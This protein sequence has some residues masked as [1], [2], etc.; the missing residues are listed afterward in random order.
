MLIRNLTNLTNWS[1]LIQCMRIVHLIDYFQPKI[2]YQETFLAREHAKL[3][4]DVTVVT[5]DRYFPFPDYESTFTK[6]LGERYVGTGK[7]TEEGIA[8]WRLPSWEIPKSPLVLLK[9]LEQTLKTVQSDVVFCHGV[10][11]LTSYMAARLKN[12]VGYTLVYDSHA[13]AFNTPLTDTLAKRWYFFLYQHVFAPVIKKGMNHLFAVGDDEQ[14]FLRETLKLVDYDVPIIRLGVDIGRFRFSQKERG[15]IRKELGISEKEVVVVCA[16]KMGKE[17]DIPV[18]AEAVNRLRQTNV[19]LLLI[20]GGLDEHVTDRA[21]LPA[22]QVRD[23][24]RRNIVHLPYVSNEK[25]PS[26]F[27]T[28]DIGVWPGNFTMTILEA[29]SC[30][31]PVILPKQSSAMYLDKSNG[32]QW[33]TRGNAQKLSERIELLAAS[34]DKR[35][36]L[37]K[38]ARAYTQKELSWHVIAN[39]TLHLISKH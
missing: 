35:M 33:F 22:R 3:G 16:G 11:S 26:Y 14:K 25:L 30:S 27:S 12:R 15:R 1:N 23:P 37:G 9:S 4:H 18:L 28:A 17:K 8:T 39:Q 19:R 21:C 5:S 31:L 13:A 29:M 24:L 36:R 32:V 20:G 2:G 34:A 38:N 6:V 10:Y 7:R